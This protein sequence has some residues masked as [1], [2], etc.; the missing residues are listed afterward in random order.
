MEKLCR[1]V[2]MVAAIT[3]QG[4][5]D[6]PKGKSQSVRSI[7]TA[8]LNMQTNMTFGLVL[9]ST[10][11]QSGHP[12]TLRTQTIE[13]TDFSDVITSISRNKALFI[14]LKHQLNEYRR[15][16]YGIDPVQSTYLTQSYYVDSRLEDIHIL[17]GY[18]DVRFW[19]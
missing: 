1:R 11:R 17:F 19:F 3:I 4:K 2:S 5:R 10:P 12:A 8:V 9:A 7:N 15:S 18:R 16:K 14:E 13:P 6:R